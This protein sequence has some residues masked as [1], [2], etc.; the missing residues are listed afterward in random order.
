M[1]KKR[2]TTPAVE[3]VRVDNTTLLAGSLGSNSTP[4]INLNDAQVENNEWDAD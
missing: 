1:N 4:T 2:Y 3:V